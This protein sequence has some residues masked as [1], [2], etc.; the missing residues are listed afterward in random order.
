MGQFVLTTPAGVTAKILTYGATVAELRVP[1][2]SGKLADVLLGFDDIKGWQS[3]GNPFFD[4]VVGRYANRIAKGKFT[5]D[6]TT[7]E[8]ATNNGPN[9]L[10]GGTAGFDKK[11]WKAEKPTLVKDKEGH[12]IGAGSP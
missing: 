6:G 8:L 2:A 7:Y 4:C 3:Q 1:D 5:L 10:H 11:V 12:E 9:H